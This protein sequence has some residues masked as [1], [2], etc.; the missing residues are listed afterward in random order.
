IIP[1]LSQEWEV[2]FRFK[3]TGSVNDKW[4]NI[5]QLTKGGKLEEYGDRTPGIFYNKEIQNLVT[6]SAVNG[7]EG[8]RN[9]FPIE[10]NTEYN[11]EIH[12]RY[13]S[14]G[15]YKYSILLNGDEVHST[16]NT[17]ARQFY[18]VKVYT[19]SPWS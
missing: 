4:C 16:D 11:V 8:Y 12:Q 14:G 10:L 13:K 5:L 19:G 7:N 1:R 17:Q 9:Y 3:L 6:Y 15:V 18:D 2:R